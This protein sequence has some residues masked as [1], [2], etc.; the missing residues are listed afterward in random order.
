MTQASVTQGEGQ[1]LTEEYAEKQ[2]KK[3]YH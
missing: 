1:S 3:E 2:S